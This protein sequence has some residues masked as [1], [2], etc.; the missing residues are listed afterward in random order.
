MYRIVELPEDLVDD[1]ESKV[2]YCNSLWLALPD[3][4]RLIGKNPDA[5]IFI[6]ETATGKI[7]K[8]SKEMNKFL[9][10]EK[11]EMILIFEEDE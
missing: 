1:E 11:L 5:L 9:F 3:F 4:Y 10:P 7:I 2:T 6:Q 8:A